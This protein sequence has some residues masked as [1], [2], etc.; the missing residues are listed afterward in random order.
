MSSVLRSIYLGL[1]QFR[2]TRRTA[3][4]VRARI[5][6]I[7]GYTDPFL[8]LA[9]ICKQSKAELFLD[10]GCH[11]GE[12]LERFLESGIDCPVTAFD[13]IA[14]NIQATRNRIPNSNRVS[15]VQAALSDTDGTASFFVNKNEQ[16]SSLLDNDRGNTQSFFEECKHVERIDV[17]TLRLD[18][19]ISS[20]SK[21]F[22][23]IVVKCDT[24]GA[25]GKVVRGGLMTLRES[26]SAFYCEV[27]IGKMYQGQLGFDQLNEFL[28]TDCGLLLKNIYPCL[29][30]SCGRA[31]QFDA[32]WVKPAFLRAG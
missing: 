13:P 15:L 9:G 14:A 32:L 8:D 29:H 7:A 23:S 25:E 31:V 30:D 28:E 22:K 16:T 1:L 4:L 21:S 11:N 19:W 6:R 17:T 5:Q 3:R 12:T 18:T 10:I 27:M 24:Q 26:V 20:Q 2:P